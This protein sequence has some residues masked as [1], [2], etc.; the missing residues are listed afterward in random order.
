M[1]KT[2]TVIGLV[3][4]MLLSVSYAYAQDRKADPR[5]HGK[6]FWGKEHKSL[7][8]P[9]QRVK[10]KELRRK[11]VGENAQLIGGMVTKRLELL[12]L[13]SDSKADPQAILAKEK[14][15]R[16]LQN[17]MKDKVVQGMVEARQFLTPEQ[18]ANWKPGWLMGHRK[19]MQGSGMMGHG[20]RMGPGEDDL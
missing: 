9:E 13:W 17:Q 20:H 4:V 3:A 6:E 5:P 8:T 18:I 10:F 16:D 11:F 19:R 2:L 15:L 1:K 14:E 7:F 12:S